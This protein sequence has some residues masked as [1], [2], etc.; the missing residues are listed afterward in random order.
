MATITPLDILR[1]RNGNTYPIPKS[2]AYVDVRFF[3]AATAESHTSP[4]G[5]MWVIATPTVDSY[6][7]TSGTAVVPSADVTDGTASTFCPA[8]VKTPFCVG[9]DTTISVIAT[10][11]GSVQLEYYS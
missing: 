7:N 1:D 2:A 5:A 4:T 11:A 6:I 9:G 10:V 8:G 3:A